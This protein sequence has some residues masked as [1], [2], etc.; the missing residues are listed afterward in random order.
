MLDQAKIGSL[1]ANPIGIVIQGS[2]KQVYNSIPVS[3]VTDIHLWLFCI[4]SPII[5]GMPRYMIEGLLAARVTDIPAFLPG[6]IIPPGS[7][8][9]SKLG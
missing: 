7:C 5:T 4:P 9:T 1:V 2:P 8:P 6:P 3:R